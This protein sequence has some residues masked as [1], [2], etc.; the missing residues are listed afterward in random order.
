MSAY[1]HS[2]PNGRPVHPACRRLDE[3]HAECTCDAEWLV[4]TGSNYHRAIELYER[5]ESR[6]RVMPQ[7]HGMDADDAEA[8]DG[9]TLGLPS[10]PA[11]EDLTGFWKES[12]FLKTSE[13]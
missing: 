4:Y 7:G 2:Q 13:K 11:G 1:T 10:N 3:P 6:R 12:E 5:L 9:Q 8:L